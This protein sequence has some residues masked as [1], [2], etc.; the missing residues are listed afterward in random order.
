MEQF[1]VVSFYTKNDN[2]DYTPGAKNL[3]TSMEK[4]NLDTSHIDLLP[5][6]ARDTWETN[7]SKKPEFIKEK[8]K[9][10][11]TPIVW[12]DADSAF[13][14]YPKLF[15]ELND[16]EFAFYSEDSNPFKGAFSGTL[17]FK[18]TITM[19]EFIDDW[20]DRNNYNYNKYTLRRSRYYKGDQK[21]LE[22]I[23]K[24][25]W[26]PSRVCKC[27][28]TLGHKEL[29]LKRL[30]QSYCKIFDADKRR[31]RRLKRVT[32]DPK[33]INDMILSFK[34][35]PVIEHYQYSRKFYLNKHNRTRKT[36]RSFFEE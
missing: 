7:V 28:N 8:L 15:H 6:G 35:K 1:T 25:K 13:L 34:N 33:I 18:P 3:I 27:C 12:T 4:F 20:I 10:L 22:Q 30:P 31:L 11:N 32:S 24:Y 5:S 2:I 36:N 9:S 21:G 14:Q 17:Y 19:F 23:F 26:D 29:K 16:Y